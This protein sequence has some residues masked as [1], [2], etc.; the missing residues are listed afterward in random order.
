MMNFVNQLKAS[1]KKFIISLPD[2]L[3][4]TIIMEL[5]PCTLSYI[6]LAL[7]TSALAA[8]RVVTFVRHVLR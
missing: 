1:L 2:I 4:Y 7:A 8:S 6:N 3:S 5:D